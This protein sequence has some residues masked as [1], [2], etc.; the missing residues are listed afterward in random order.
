MPL[1][2]KLV[3]DVVTPERKLLSETVD[4]VILP[5][6]EGY[7]GV[8]PG[9]APLLTSLKIGEVNTGRGPR[10]TRSRSRGDSRRSSPTA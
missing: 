6:R 10:S 7:L 8:L 1:P 9:H 3:L 2:T 5:G 4:E